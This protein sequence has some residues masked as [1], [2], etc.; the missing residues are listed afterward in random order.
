[1][2]KKWSASGAASF[3]SGEIDKDNRTQICSELQEN[4]YK[5][6]VPPAFFDALCDAIGLFNSE[7][8]LA[9][10]SKPSE[11]RKNLKAATDAARMLQH[12]LCDLDS[13]SKLLLIEVLGD[14]MSAP[15]EEYLS[16]VIDVLIKSA[17]IAKEYP[18]KG[19]LV[20]RS[21]VLLAAEVAYAI[22]KHL[23]EVP[24]TTK[25]G[26]FESVLTIVLRIATGKEV[27][28][29]HDLMRRALKVERKVDEFDTIEYT[30]PKD[31]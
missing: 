7:R 24:S 30:H 26:I 23:G 14:E 12:K 22:E 15:Q 6:E 27:S 17:D 20:E 10:N 9:E 1:M 28:S 18:N 5:S 16:I 31:D 29:V 19:R 4:G 3:R 13:N 21:R 25:E 8:K 11:M 2:S